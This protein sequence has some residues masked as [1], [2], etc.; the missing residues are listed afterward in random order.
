ML[1]LRYEAFFAV[2]A[3]LSFSKAAEAL[4]I[5]QP[6]VSKQVKVLESEI[7]IPLFQ[8]TGNSI[9]LTSSGEKLFQ[10]LKKAK[11]IQR[12]IESDVEIIKNNL[13]ARGELKIGASTTISLY[14]MP[15]I[16]SSFHKK[17]P[18]VKILLINRNSENIVKALMDQEID[19]A[20]IE[21]H[22]QINTVHFESFM[23]DEI[24]PICAKSSPYAQAEIELEDLKKIPI[25]LR[26]RGS[27]SL[28]VL[29]KALEAKQIKIVD[30]DVIARLG[31]TEALKNYLIEG[32]AVGFLSRL[33]V[34]KEIDNGELREV[35]VKGLQI[36]RKFN[37]VVR[38]GEDSN[39]L[40]KAIM[41]EAKS[42]YNS[43][44]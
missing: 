43:K 44:L 9:S 4:F 19:L 27:G 33:S 8:R 7:G 38:K 16:L 32:D 28:V 31:G 5:T 29:K 3:H 2:A 24:I 10:Y 34:K 36:H 39:G 15:K 20:I 23:H 41:K 35:K 12:Q 13:T 30:L 42:L 40:I 18:N 26:E 25:A 37:F 11:I 17:F 6:A 1:A 22:F 14:V 21:T